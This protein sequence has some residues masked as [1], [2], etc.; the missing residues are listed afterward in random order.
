MTKLPELI[1]EADMVDTVAHWVD[2]VAEWLTTEAARLTL[3]SHMRARLRQ[4]T[5]PTMQVIAAADAGHQDADMALREIAAEYIDCGEVMPTALANYVQRALV[6]PP[7]TYP[8]GRNIADTWLRDVGIVV[9]VQLAVDR[10]HLKAT[11]NR[12]STKPSACYVVSLALV[13]R[14]INVGERQVERIYGD[15][16]RLAPRLSASIRPL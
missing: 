6:M 10:W 14:R 15:H 11:R 12:A 3:R 8:P 2:L 5:L 1:P 4:G 9:L 16:G 7:T 13:R